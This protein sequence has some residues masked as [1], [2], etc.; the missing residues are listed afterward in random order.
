VRHSS[1]S[2]CNHSPGTW[3]NR[4]ES[5]SC[6]GVATPHGSK[7]RDSRRVGGRGDGG[8]LGPHGRLLACSPWRVSSCGVG[9][10]FTIGEGNG[11]MATADGIYRW[12]GK[13]NP[14]RSDQVA[15]RTWW[16]WALRPYVGHWSWSPP[17]YHY[18]AFYDPFEFFHFRGIRISFMN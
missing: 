1:L 15:S 5:Y 6:Q 8:Y 18:I 3:T 17:V 13:R 7:R 9:G 10:G 11:R 12:G 14:K 16:A 4:V 2:L